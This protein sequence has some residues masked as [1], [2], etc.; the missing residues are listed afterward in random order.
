MVGWCPIHEAATRRQDAGAAP[1][2]RAADGLR[3]AP[4]LDG[5]D[6][7]PVVVT[8]AGDASEGALAGL[9]REARD[10]IGAQLRGRG[11]I[12]FRGF[13]IDGPDGFGRCVAA[14]DAA[15][16]SYLGGDSPR[17]RVA[18]DIFTSTE[19]PP[20]ETISLHQEMSY[21]PRWPR[22]L[23][24][25]AAEPSARGGQTS[26]AS[27]RHVTQ[28]LPA[29]LSARFAEKR[30]RYVRN[31]KAGLAL[32]KSWQSTYQTSD[33]R[34]VERHAEAQGSRCE[35]A[36][37]GSLRVTTECDA[38][39]ADP[40]DGAPLWFNQAEQWHPSALNGT[41]RTLFEQMLGKGNFPHECTHGDGSPLAD[42]DLAAVRDALAG[43]KLLFDW[44]RNDLLLIDNLL[45]MHG[46]EPFEGPR[47]VLVYLS[48][49]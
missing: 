30:L 12:L 20:S 1:P 7:G 38:Y 19:Y 42:A 23:L 48:A 13:D 33:R 15:P 3:A 41:V 4:L 36:P 49:N 8:P 29:S 28:A 22:R 21:L 11:A 16:F 35:W 14:L 24:F 47:R 44:Q 37:D 46:R 25:Y 6:H 39:C 2:P 9:M 18:E 26:L 32:G 27:A 10:E 45:M 31:F 43:A 40:A 34:Q 5:V 17:T